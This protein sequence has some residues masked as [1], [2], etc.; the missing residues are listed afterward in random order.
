MFPIPRA[1]VLFGCAAL[2]AHLSTSPRVSA[3]AEVGDLLA[4]GRVIVKVYVTMPQPGRPYGRPLEGVTLVMLAAN[5][6][7]T[8]VETD[9]AGTTKIALAPGTYHVTS[10]PI[11]W[12][13]K[14]YRWEVTL[15]VR[16][17]MP[18]LDLTPKNAITL[19]AGHI[20]EAVAPSSPRTT[21]GNVVP[22][23]V[24]T[25]KKGTS[26]SQ[27]APPNSLYKSPG[28]AAL[29]SLLITGGGQMYN[30]QVGKGTALLVLNIGSIVAGAAASSRA[31][32][33]PGYGCSDANLTPLYV[34]AT[35][36]VVTWI[37]SMTDAYNT[38]EAHNAELEFR[39]GAQSRVQPVLAPG[40]DRRVL[41]GLSLSH[42][43]RAR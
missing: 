3:Q 35:V 11:E 38:A 5:G 2:I 8:E 7:R 10:G 43:R 22:S 24:T 20:A 19:E 28:R 31:V 12:Q 21:P 1:R 17:G 40:S 18:L 6:E 29:I 4:D 15:A 39:A 16:G 32:C 9:A 30:G 27:V 42:S 37:Y 25:P 41:I 34:G 26:S 33:S 23:D 14:R 36:A 13:G